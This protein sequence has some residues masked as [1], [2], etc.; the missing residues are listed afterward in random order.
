MC[1]SAK[2]IADVIAAATNGEN[3]H[4]RAGQPGERA[5]Y[6]H[7]ERLT[8]QYVE[9]QR[10]KALCGKYFVPRQDPNGLPMCPDCEGVYRSIT[11]GEG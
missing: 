3:H 9:G 7:K 2:Q 1:D 8:E 11:S 5:H 6:T 4:P 10:A